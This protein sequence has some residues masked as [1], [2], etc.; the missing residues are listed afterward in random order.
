VHGD[1]A[2][3]HE[4]RWVE[5]CDRGGEHVAKQLSGPLGQFERA[6]VVLT[7]QS[8]DIR[9]TLDLFS[10]LVAEGTGDGG[11]AR[12]GGEATE[13][14]AG[15]PVAGVRVEEADVADVA[16]DT[17]DASLGLAMEDHAGADAGADLHKQQAWGL[18]VASARFAQTHQVGVVVDEDRQAKDSAESFETG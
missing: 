2:T 14:A 16:G 9:G 8:A 10:A 15:V 17:G 5:E 4:D 7:E 3:D 12:F 6:G 18:G 1:S 13:R 11:T